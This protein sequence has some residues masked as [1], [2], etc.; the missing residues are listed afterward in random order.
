MILLLFVRII[1]GI[2][3]L[4]LA[5]SLIIY[6][7]AFGKRWEP[8]GIIKYYS[9]DEYENFKGDDIS[10][11]TKKGVLRGKRYYYQN[12]SYKGIIVFSHG[13][14]GSHQ[15]YI[16]EIEILAAHG[17][18][19]LAI[20]A[21]GT[22]LSDGKA[23]KGLGNSLF[24][25]DEA[26]KYAKK[27]FNPK[28]IYVMG[29]SWGGYAALNISNIH[30]DINKAVIMSPFISIKAILKV[31]IPKYLYIC[32]PFLILFDYFYFGKYSLYNGQESVKMTKIKT[33]ILHSRDDKVIPYNKSTLL[34]EKAGNSNVSFYIVDGKNHN[35]DYSLAAIN[36]TKECANR[37]N[38]IKEKELKLAYKKS[39]DYHKMGE[40][41]MDVFKAIL[42]FLEGENK[43]E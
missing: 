1:L 5:V 19:V 12:D 17:Y 27:Y 28:D 40:I 32:I 20:D 22:E 42:D 36:Y 18:Y 11:T 14:W 34:L 10:I 30:N 35:P 23:I 37:L 33:L 31:F 7:K 41:D 43:N 16:Q 9:I 21:Y 25:L 6:Y 4:I 2:I 24:V 13:M 8:D 15:A 29:H 39:L 3:A 26:I 38:G